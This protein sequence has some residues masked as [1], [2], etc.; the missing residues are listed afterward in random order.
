MGIFFFIVLEQV[1][2]MECIWAT[3]SPG[4]AVPV[5]AAA[6]QMNQSLRKNLN[7]C[8][9]LVQTVFVELPAERPRC[10]SSAAW[11]SIDNIIVRML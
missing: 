10:E 9:S 7:L 2:A 11:G 1:H 8:L 3:F 5:Q 6:G 4:A